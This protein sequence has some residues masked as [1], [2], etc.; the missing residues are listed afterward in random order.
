MLERFEKLK[1][2][3]QA[4]TVV[5]VTLP[6]A[7]A[8]AIYYDLTGKGSVAMTIGG[9]VVGLLGIAVAISRVVQ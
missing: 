3:W 5:L 6:V 7:L 4:V 8:P 9:I 2:T 1:P